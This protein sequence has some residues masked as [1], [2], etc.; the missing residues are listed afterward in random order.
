MSVLG[1]IP[2]R[3]GS[4]R[5]PRKNLRELG[6]EPLVAWSISCALKTFG[7]DCVAVSSEDNEI[8]DVAKAYPVEIIKRPMKLATDEASSY[9]TIIHALDELGPFESVC[10]LQPTS[11]L[12]WP[13]DVDECIDLHEDAE[14]GAVVSCEHGKE[15]PNGAIYVG[16]TDW[17][18]EMLAMGNTHPFDSTHVRRYFMPAWRSIDIDTEDDLEMAKRALYEKLSEVI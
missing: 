3:G 1:L 18:R 2:A 9:D 16:Y 8:L 17:L 14:A 12:R 13:S 15:V 7:L 4:K 10:L 6:G 5:V 11:P